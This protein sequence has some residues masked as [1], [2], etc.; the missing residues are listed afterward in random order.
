MG[1]FVAVDYSHLIL[2]HLTPWSLL[3]TTRVVF[4]S[5]RA[6]GLLIGQRLGN[7]QHADPRILTEE[8]QSP[9]S[10]LRWTYLPLVSLDHSCSGTSGVSH[11][12]S[13]GHISIYGNCLEQS[14]RFCW[15]E[16]PE[17][18]VDYT[19]F[20]GNCRSPQSARAPSYPLYYMQLVKNYLSSPKFPDFGVQKCP[21]LLSKTSLFISAG[22]LWGESARARRRTSAA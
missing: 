9:P 5:L 15:P 16:F 13:T 18:C 12:F 2:D 22:L 11:E 1:S 21:Q 7:V 4:K 10:I 20:F 8:F 14:C 6:S 17:S 19:P 3:W